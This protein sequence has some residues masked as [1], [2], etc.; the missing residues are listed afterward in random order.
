MIFLRKFCALLILC[1]VF[2]TSCSPI[3]SADDS[4]VEKLYTVLTEFSLTEGAVYSTEEN[5]DYFFTDA[6]AERMFFWGRDISALS[7]AESTAVYV[8]RRFS[9]EEIVVA[10]LHDLSHRDEV[11]TLFLSRA[12]KKKNAIVFCDGVYVYLV[13]AE[14]R[15]EIKRFLTK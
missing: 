6:M 4:A 2:F 1:A 13:C 7:H 9:S 15:D 8:S 10:K 12:E 5:E 3:F 14:N 11:E